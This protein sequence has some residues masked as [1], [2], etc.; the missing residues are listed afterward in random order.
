MGRRKTSGF[1]ACSH[2]EGSEAFLNKARAVPLEKASKQVTPVAL[3]FGKEVEM[4]AMVAIILDNNHM[5]SFLS[6]I[7]LLNF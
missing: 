1:I 7:H 6:V 3:A 5:G 2:R 4:R